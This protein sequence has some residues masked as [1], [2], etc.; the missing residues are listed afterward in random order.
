MKKNISGWEGEFS[1]GWEFQGGGKA[2]YEIV[3]IN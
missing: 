1:A 3:M 2:I